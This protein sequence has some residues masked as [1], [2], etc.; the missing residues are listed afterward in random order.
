MEYVASLVK[1]P[2]SDLAK[3]ADCKHAETS[4]LALLLL[5]SAL[6]DVNT[7][8]VERVLAD[9]A[10]ARRMWDADRRGLTALFWSHVNPYGTFRLDMDARLPLADTP[11]P[12][13]AAGAERARGRGP[14]CGTGPS[15]YARETCAAARG[16]GI[17]MK[18]R[19]TCHGPHRRHGRGLD[20]P[21]GRDHV[22]AR[23]DCPGADPARRRG[24]PRSGVR[25]GGDH[26]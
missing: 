17:Q 26:S 4:M 13:P 11:A 16:G 20:G 12:V 3:Y 6:V 2:P 5:Q 9:P 21:R 1:V 8:L 23:A 7:L 14:P 24:R 18:E 25:P 15:Q 19:G 10:W 22:A